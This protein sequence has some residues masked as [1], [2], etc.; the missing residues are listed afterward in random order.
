MHD[1]VVG[2]DVAVGE[3]KVWQR[4]ERRGVEAKEGKRK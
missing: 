1:F 3:K 2:D 4:R